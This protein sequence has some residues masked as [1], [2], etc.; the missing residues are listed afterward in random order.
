MLI[1]KTQTRGN[2][3]CCGRLQAV[4]AG[5]KNMSKHGYE[6]KKSSFE[7]YFSGVCGGHSFLSMQLERKV[8]DSLIKS[9][10]EDACRIDAL[11]L[12]LEAGDEF[13]KT[14]KSGKRVKGERYFEDEIVPFDQAPKH[15]QKVAVTVE[16]YKCQSRARSARVWADQMEKL[17]NEVHGQPLCIVP[18][19]AAL[20]RIQNGEKRVSLI[21]RV[22]TSY[23]V[24]G[25]SVYWQDE[26]GFKGKMVS[27]AWRALKGA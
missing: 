2:C 11:A 25:A 26:R 23:R 12:K 22:L 10:R 18:I 5:G 20:D 7:A 4:L 14:A 3:Q 24:D 16:I 1:T 27:R 8:T 6:V 13:P 15:H 19:A 9:A 17:V 21:G